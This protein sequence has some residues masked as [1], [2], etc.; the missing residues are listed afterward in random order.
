MMTGR[1]AARY[2]V[3]NRGLLRPGAAADVVVF[4]PATIAEG[5]TFDEPRRWPIGIQHVFVN[6]VAV[7]RDGGATGVRPGR[8][9]AAALDA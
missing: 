7:V 4:D 2:R 8:V 6:G 1:T 9:L 5:S 3:P